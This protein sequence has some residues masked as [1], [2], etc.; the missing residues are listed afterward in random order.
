MKQLFVPLIQREHPCED[1]RDRATVWMPT[2][3][4]ELESE[5]AHT[6]RILLLAE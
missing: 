4:G 6:L 5:V 3:V 2:L 1:P